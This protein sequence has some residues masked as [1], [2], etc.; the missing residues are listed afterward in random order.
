M[1]V[2]VDGLL[3][4]WMGNGTIDRL[5]STD[6]NLVWMSVMWTLIFGMHWTLHNPLCMSAHGAPK[7]LLQ[8]LVWDGWVHG[9]DIIK[10]GWVPFLCFV[11]Y[12]LALSNW[13][14]H[15]LQSFILNYANS[16]WV[17]HLLILESYHYLSLGQFIFKL[18]LN[19]FW[20]CTVCT[21]VRIAPYM[22]KK[23]IVKISACFIY[24]IL[25]NGLL[26]SYY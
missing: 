16:K 22:L 14:L 1:L 5:V 12:F 25:R 11:L 13:K 4:G 2:W 21:H 19:K 17:K 15:F 18:S 9:T 24:S 8:F 10:K 7:S 6:V 26:I 3:M 20:K 23:K